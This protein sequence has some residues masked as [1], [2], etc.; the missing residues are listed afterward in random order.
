MDTDLEKV[1]SESTSLQPKF[2]LLAS[3]P[4]VGRVTAV[5]LLS[6]LPELGALDRRQIAAL[7]GVAPLNCDSGQHVGKRR[8][9]GGRANVRAP[10]YMAAL[11]AKRFNPEIRAFASRL[12]SR[13]KAPK[14]ILTA[15]MRKLLVTANA[16][17]RD[18]S[19]WSP[20]PLPA[21]TALD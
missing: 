12:A 1:I 8:T 10:L 9:W 19:P 21:A 13:G 16:I 20:R 15:C 17:L 14:A 11:A 7:V 5:T 4:G 6:A 2:D 3:I 18:K